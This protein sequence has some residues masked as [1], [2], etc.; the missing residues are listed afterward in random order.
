[1]EFT[2]EHQTV[3]STE[4][5]G[6]VPP[7]GYT[8]I[9]LVDSTPR[10]VGYLFKQL[11]ITEDAWVLLPPTVPQKLCDFVESLHCFNGGLGHMQGKR[12]VTHVSRTANRAWTHTLLK[13]STP[14]S[15]S[16]D[17][18]FEA[19]HQMSFNLDFDEV[20]AF[21][22]N[23]GVCVC[24]GAVEGSLCCGQGSSRCNECVRFKA[25]AVEN[26]IYEV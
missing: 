5:T 25:A 15:D 6:H 8:V 17:T 16:L 18:F 10:S 4:E 23:L 1:M 24:K 7:T 2:A 13:D 3:A 20:I 9:R 12:Y 14:E 21:W 11:K 26:G 22:V 19:W